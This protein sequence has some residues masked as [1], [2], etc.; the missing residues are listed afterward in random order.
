M[1]S[2]IVAGSPLKALNACAILKSSMHV[3][4]SLDSSAQYVEQHCEDN[5]E[6]GTGRKESGSEAS[7]F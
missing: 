1:H 3:N 2:L 5:Q 7:S 4:F 6:D